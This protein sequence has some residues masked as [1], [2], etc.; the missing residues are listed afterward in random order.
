M[1]PNVNRMAN[2]FTFAL[3][4]KTLEILKATVYNGVTENQKLKVL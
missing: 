2:K 4:N 1:P 3:F